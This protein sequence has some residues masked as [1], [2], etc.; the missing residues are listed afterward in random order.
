VVEQPKSRD[1]HIIDDVPELRGRE[2]GPILVI[3]LDGFL[4]AG[5]AAV[6]ATDHL[7]ESSESR[8]VASLDVDSFYDYRSRRPPLSFVEDHYESYEAPRLVVRLATDS[9]GQPFLLLHGP[10]PDLRWEAFSLAVRHV[11]EHFG[12]RLTVQM[13]AVPMAVP[14]TRP[15]HLT[16]HAT[17]KSLILAENVWSGELRVP[18]SAQSL[19]EIRLGEWGHKATGFV[20]HVPHYLAQTEDK[21]AALKLIEALQVI[22]GLHW[23]NE[24]LNQAAIT[25][26]VEIDEQ[27][28][29]SDELRQLVRGL[30]E[31]YDAFHEARTG[32]ATNL[33][34]ED[35]PL[36]TGEEIG[37]EFEKFLAGLEEGED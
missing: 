35:K 32:E 22:S 5:R 2:Q 36:P 12:V 23:D 7:L 8:V 34:A 17:D 19:V 6:M 13:G 9:E 16:H 1:V 25:N 31:Q 18:A 11:V 30:E 14:H 4:D 21:T 29:Q 28:S 10:E 3:S 27:V 37:S 24:S 15:A 33:L 26:R 20:A